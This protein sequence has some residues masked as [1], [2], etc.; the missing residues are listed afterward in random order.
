L[1]ILVKMPCGRLVPSGYGRSDCSA[2][3]NFMRRFHER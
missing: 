3:R 1:E 2:L